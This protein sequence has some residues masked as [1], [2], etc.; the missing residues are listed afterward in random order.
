LWI[1]PEGLLLE[2][3]PLGTTVLYRNNNKLRRLFWE[4][5]GIRNATW[6]DYR[7]TLIQLKARPATP[8]DLEI[9]VVELYRKL[10]RCR[11]SD[12]DWGALL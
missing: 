8:P 12:E 10:A 1:G 3:I 2:K 5:L 7:D 4:F 6:T 9:K 11:I